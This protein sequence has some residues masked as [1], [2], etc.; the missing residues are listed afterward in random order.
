VPKKVHCKAV[1]TI[2]IILVVNMVSEIHIY[3]YI[4]IYETNV[5]LFRNALVTLVC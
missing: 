4:Y 5:S 2:I 1:L 3:I